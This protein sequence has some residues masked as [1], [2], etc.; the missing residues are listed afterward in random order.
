MA[1]GNI[2]NTI[3]VLI[4]ICATSLGVLLAWATWHRFYGHLDQLHRQIMTSDQA[5]YMR[6]VRL[7]N[8]A[9]IEAMT[10]RW[11]PKNERWGSHYESV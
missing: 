2:P 4:I 3:K 5:V 10:K 8:L 9:M 7:R 11:K 1:F 6:E